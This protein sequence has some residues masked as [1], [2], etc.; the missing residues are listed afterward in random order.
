MSQPGFGA[1]DITELLGELAAQLHSRGLRGEMFVVGGAAIALAYDTRRSTRDIDAVFAPKS[2]VYAA[3]AVVAR[4]R[5]IP[6]DWLNDAVKGFLPGPDPDPRPVFDAPGLRVDVASPRYLLAMKLLASRDDDVD[7]I[8]T[9][10]TACGFTR[11]AEGLDLVE[12]T[13]PARLISPRVRFL[14]EDLYPAE[15]PAGGR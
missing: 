3:A 12:S 5:G 10:F 8:R 11:A 4:R 1:A 15:D 9:L 14:L 13:F 6:T 2:E 7:D